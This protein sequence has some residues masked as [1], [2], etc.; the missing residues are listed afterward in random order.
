M[1]PTKLEKQAKEIR[2]FSHA[3]ECPIRTGE[4]LPSWKN[5]TCSRGYIIHTLVSS[6]ETKEFEVRNEAYE[7]GFKAANIVGKTIP[8]SEVE[9]YVKK[10]EAWSPLTEFGMADGG[11]TKNMILKDLK[12]ILHRRTNETN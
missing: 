7:D 2:S 1:K 8:I 12:E 6:I 4:V 5:C 9:E 11:I 10:L 3:E